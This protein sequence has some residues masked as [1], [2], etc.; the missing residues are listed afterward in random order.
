MTI[1]A[2]AALSWVLPGE[3]CRETAALRDRATED[4]GLALLVPP[5]FWYE[6][7]NSLWVSIRRGRLD[8]EN[9]MAILEALVDFRF[10]TWVPD[11]GD[12][13]SLAL[14]HNIAAYDSAYLQV[15][16]DV[17][18]PLWT[19]DRQLA[20]AAMSSGLVVEPVPASPSALP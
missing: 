9:A 20:H 15:A 10:E 17:G 2:S 16:L 12:C 4:P 13:L 1:D 3:Q 5:V 7:S 18:S 19:V 6:I 14:Y 8:H 11:P